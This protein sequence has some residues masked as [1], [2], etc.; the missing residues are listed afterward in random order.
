MFIV[1]ILY[2]VTLG[3]HYVGFTG[4]LP[5]RLRRHNS[6]SKGFTGCASDWTVVYQESYVDKE[7]ARRREQE[8]KSWKSRVLLE[9]LIGSV[10]L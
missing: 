1:Y 5:E 9:K 3:R 6:Y 2:S 8:I 10:G 4:N 7:I